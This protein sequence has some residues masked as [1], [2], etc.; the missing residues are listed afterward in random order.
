[1]EAKVT[2]ISPVILKAIYHAI[3]SIGKE[4]E[5]Q[6]KPIL[7]KTPAMAQPRTLNSLGV[8]IYH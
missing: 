1:M 3:E 6:N 2:S 8:G 7:G 5:L 4:C